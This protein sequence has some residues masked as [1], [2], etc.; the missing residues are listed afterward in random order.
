[1]FIMFIY[2]NLFIL[3]FAEN[4]LDLTWCREVA[5]GYELERQLEHVAPGLFLFK[6]FLHVHLYLG[7]NDFFLLSFYLGRSTIAY[8]TITYRKHVNVFHMHTYTHTYIHTYIHTCMHTYIH[9]YK[10][11]YMHACMHTYILT[12]LHT[13]ILTYL[14]TWISVIFV[15]WFDSNTRT[16]VRIII[17][18]TLM[19]D[20]LDR[21]VRGILRWLMH[22][23]RVWK[24]YFDFLGCIYIERER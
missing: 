21:P 16:G 7:R 18:T 9:T 20:P 3:Y 19:S 12:Y 2:S 11:A 14:H 5:H 23:Q 8:S 10:H 22:V 4:S 1:M 24:A 13:Y 6:C 17:P 15:V